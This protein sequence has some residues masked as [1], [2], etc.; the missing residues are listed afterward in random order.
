MFHYI[1]DPKASYDKKYD[2]LYVGLPDFKNAV[3]YDEDCDIVVMRDEKDNTVKGYIFEDFVANY[4]EGQ[5][6]NFAFPVKVDL[7][8]FY[9]KVKL[10]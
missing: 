4:L 1:S 2:I 7:D 3:G 10:I 9:N 8:W 5:Y 6:K